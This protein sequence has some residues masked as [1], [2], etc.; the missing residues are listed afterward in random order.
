MSVAWRQHWRFLTVCVVLLVA[1]VVGMGDV[2]IR[3]YITGDASV[4][5]SSVT[6]N[7]AGTTDLFDAEE[8]HVV[9]L[10][11]EDGEWSSM[12][13]AYESTGDK[14]WITADLTIDGELIP[15]VAVR[16]K[17]NSTLQGLRREDSGQG[18]GRPTPPGEFEPP[19]GMEMPEGVEPPA[20]ME[21]PPGGGGGPGM[22]AGI[23]ADDP[24]SLPLLIS[25]DRNYEGRAYQGLTE[26]SIRPG[27]PVLNEA[28]ALDLTSATG[29]ES[30][31]YAYSEYSVN[32]GATT[33]RLVLEH[34]DA[35]YADSLFD[36]AGYLYK[37]DSSSRFEYVG[38]DQSE[39]ADQFTQI[40]AADD[41]TLQP[42]ID[43]L[44]WVDSA[45]DEQFAAELDQ[46][47]DV[48]SFA[49][50]VATQNLLGNSDDI[51]GPGQNYYLWY[52]LE[53][54]K[55][56]VLSWD[57]NLTMSGD[58][59]SGPDDSTSIG[60]GRG[61]GGMRGMPGG[62]ADAGPGGMPG[63]APEGAMPRGGDG[64]PSPG[65]NKLKERFLESEAFDEV[66]EGTYWDLYD[67]IYG[68]GL[69]LATLEQAVASFPL[70]DGIDQTALDEAAATLRSWIEQRTQALADQRPVCQEV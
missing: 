25:F 70:S 23:S 7:V 47:V 11:V 13:D 35:G 8:S 53:T 10:D 49:A 28:V 19:A 45:D 30:Q 18:E 14:K 63:E 36:G 26:L 67:Q 38:E 4:I 22:G 61:P 12:I 50:Y 40:N 69:A 68:S 32:D 33:T 37:A 42:V 60:G 57:L 58:T 51:S 34:P 56:T 46:W 16:L 64:A 17:G 48:E 31:R 43:L 65:G 5:T 3:P 6:Q 27:T 62:D 59:S 44:K 21:M 54:E 24:S 20:G 15:D 1:V 66:Y 29:Q 55:F 41:G 52:D 9:H 2:R 39:Y